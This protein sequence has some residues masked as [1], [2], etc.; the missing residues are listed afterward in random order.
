MLP[1]YNFSNNFFVTK[2]NVKMHYVQEGE[3]P[4]VLLVHGNPTWSFF[5]RNV[6]NKLKS[7]HKVIAPDHI[8]CGLS[9]KPQKYPYT[10]SQHIEN[11]Q[12]LMSHLG[13]E[14]FSIVVHDWGGAI[15]LGYAGQ[16]AECVDKIVAMNTAAFR[17][18]LIPLRIR[19][20]RLPLLGEIIVRLFNGFAW[21]AKYMAVEKPLP[22]EVAKGYLQ[23]YNNW[24]NRIAV[25]RFVQ[26]IP[27]GPGHPSYQTLVDVEKNLSRFSERK[28]PLMLLWGGAD[29][30]FN[31]DF[32]DEGLRRFPYAVT[33]F[34]PDAGLYILVDKRDEA[35]SLI[36][37]FLAPHGLKRNKI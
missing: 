5:Y 11:L 15:G 32:P 14:R 3:G 16:K 8:G 19:L 33:H 34:F 36:D 22:A 13:E 10:L 12:Q 27:M 31:K 26:D 25:A 35:V 18:P 2:E 30:C 29:F 17:S 4:T 7:A 1:D 24:N 28:V 23:P 21:P 6:I 20:C 9:D 37:N